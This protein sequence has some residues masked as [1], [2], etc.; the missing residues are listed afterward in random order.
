MSLT[1]I[2]HCR[3]LIH[4]NALLSSSLPDLENRLMSRFHEIPN[5]T[6]DLVLYLYYSP[7]VVSKAPPRFVSSTLCRSDLNYCLFSPF[8][9]RVATSFWGINQ[10]WCRYSFAQME[11]A[12]SL[13]NI[14]RFFQV[15]TTVPSYK[16]ESS[17]H[18]SLCLKLCDPLR[19]PC[20]RPPKM[21]ID[22]FYLF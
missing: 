12:L 18:H 13:H 10:L 11:T 21:I 20:P 4:N 15:S 14:P 1:G 16:N 7:E 5:V 9:Y 2:F 6:R 3:L 8:A 17:F 19:I 22:F